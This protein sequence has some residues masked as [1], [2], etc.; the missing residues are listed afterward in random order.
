MR[1]LFVCAAFILSACFAGC[2]R[3]PDLPDESRMHLGAIVNRV[4][5]ELHDAVAA[6]PRYHPWLLKWAAGMELSLKVKAEGAGSASSDYIWP[7]QLG[8]FKLALS[9]GLKENAVRTALF[10]I[11]MPLEYTLHYPCPLEPAY[12]PSRRDLTGDLGLREWVERAVDAVAESDSQ[13]QFNGMGHRMEFFLQAAGG[14]SGNWM[15]VRSNGH[16]FNPIVGIGGTRENTNTVDIALVRIPGVAGVQH[17]WVDNLPGPQGILPEGAPGAERIRPRV[18]ERG[19]DP[20]TQQRLDSIIQ[21]LQ[22]KNLKI[23]N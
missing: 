6:H 1:I 7:I 4:K 18:H 11:S 17:V 19:V 9:G 15:I 8:T 12:G 10:K 16:K 5:C 23:E 14:V 22:L 20:G 13:Q 3:T 21:D 2:V